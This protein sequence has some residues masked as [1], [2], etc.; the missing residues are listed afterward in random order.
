MFHCAYNSAK[1]LTFDYISDDPT[2]RD[3]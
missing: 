1:E 3:M 2:S